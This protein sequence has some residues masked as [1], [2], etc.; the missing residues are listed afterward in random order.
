M[1]ASAIAGAKR[2][3]QIITWTDEDAVAVD[4]TGATITARIRNRTTGVVAASDGAFTVT[5]GAAGQ[6]RWD[7]STTDVATA[8]IYDVQFNAAFGTAPTPARNFTTHWSIH[9]AI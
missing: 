5:D 3:S 1:L 8:G 6:F 7:Y 9:E 4:L 2:P